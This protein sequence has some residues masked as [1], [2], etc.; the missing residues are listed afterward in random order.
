MVHRPFKWPWASIQ[1]LVA[2]QRVV[3]FFE[4]HRHRQIVMPVF[5][6]LFLVDKGLD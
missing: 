6:S 2:G 1:V 3:I 4:S 5:F